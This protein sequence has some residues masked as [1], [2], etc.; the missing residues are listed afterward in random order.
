MGNPEQGLALVYCVCWGVRTVLVKCSCAI[1]HDSQDPLACLLVICL[2]TVR[3]MA[4]EGPKPS[5]YPLNTQPR[6]V[7]VGGTRA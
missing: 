7:Q 1:L 3:V 5:G 6:T 2:P 4:G